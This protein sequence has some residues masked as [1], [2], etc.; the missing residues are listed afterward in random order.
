[1]VLVLR[2][3]WRRCVICYEYRWETFAVRGLGGRQL[4]HIRRNEILSISPLTAAQRI[5]RF[6]RYKWLIRSGFKP[7]VVIRSNIAHAKPVIV[8]WEGRRIAGIK[9][10]GCKLRPEEPGPRAGPRG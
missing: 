2:E 7:K 1:M 10:D 8:S 9:P 4:L 5:S 3:F 6:G